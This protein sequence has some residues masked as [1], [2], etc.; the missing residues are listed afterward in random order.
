MVSTS[1]DGTSS[2]K[3]SFKRIPDIMVRETDS[4]GKIMA[5]ETGKLAS[6]DPSHHRE[7]FFT[8][9]LNKFLE[10]YLCFA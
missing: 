10:V 6:L 4:L 5:R 3:M 2:C 7:M 9:I 8:R 1:T